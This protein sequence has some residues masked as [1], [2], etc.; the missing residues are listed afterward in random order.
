MDTTTVAKG[1]GRYIYKI[2]DNKWRYSFFLY[3][4]ICILYKDKSPY[5]VDI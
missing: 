4:I 5:I 3:I 2:Y 1:Y